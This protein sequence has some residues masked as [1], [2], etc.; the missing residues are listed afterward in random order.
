LN[1]QAAA[2]VFLE[3]ENK[4]RALNLTT[5]ADLSESSRKTGGLPAAVGL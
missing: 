1:E 2:R 5:G 3:G 4:V